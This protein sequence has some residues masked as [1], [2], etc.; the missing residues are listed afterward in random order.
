MIMKSQPREANELVASECESVCVCLCAYEC[1]MCECWVLMMEIFE[2]QI[3]VH[4]YLLRYL[5]GVKNFKR[6]C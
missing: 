3:L 4:T 2:A 1:G 6:F 5:L